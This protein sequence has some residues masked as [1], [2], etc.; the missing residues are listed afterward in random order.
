MCVEFVIDSVYVHL[1]YDEISLTFTAG[2]VC[3]SDVC[4]HVI[5]F[6]LSVY[7]V[8]TVVT[9]MLALFVLHVCMLR[10]RGCEDDGNSGMGTG[11]CCECGMYMEGTRGLG[12]A[13]TADD[14]L[15]M[16]EVHGVECVK[17]VCARLGAG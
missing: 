7:T 4:S 13:S 12:F 14:V 11:G 2:N 3:L 1:Q 16:S 15:D 6:G 8:Y 5:V 17:C 10:V 9:V